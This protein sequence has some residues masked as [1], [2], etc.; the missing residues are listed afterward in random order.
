MNKKSNNQTD[1]QLLDQ[2]P[3]EGK[4]KDIRRA[5]VQENNYFKNHPEDELRKRYLKF[6]AFM[7]TMYETLEL[8]RNATMEQFAQRVY[9]IV[10]AACPPEEKDLENLSD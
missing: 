5:K 6:N 8:P 7:E 9:D 2:Y 3:N 4:I 10:M 1:Q